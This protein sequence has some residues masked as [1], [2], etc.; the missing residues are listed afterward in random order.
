MGGGDK[1]ME[2]QIFQKNRC[3]KNGFGKSYEALKAWH[4]GEVGKCDIWGKAVG[5]CRMWGALGGESERQKTPPPKHAGG[6]V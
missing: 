2:T 5:K 1:T 4:L 6:C 3:P